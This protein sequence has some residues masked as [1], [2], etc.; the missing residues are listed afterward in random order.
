MIEERMRTSRR[1]VRRGA[2]IGLAAALAAI[3]A[4]PAAAQESLAT[5]SCLVPDS[6]S[7]HLGRIARRVGNDVGI[8]AI[9]VESGVRV[10]FNGERTFPMASV[11]K[12]PM[13]LEYLR[14]VDAGEIDPSERIVVPIT[15]FRP[16]NSPLASWSGGRA[17]HVTIDSLFGLMIGASDNTATDVILELSGGPEAADRRIRDLGVR[18]VR[19]DR[20]EAR[21]FADLSGLPDTIPESELYR[22]RYF[23]LRDGLEQTHRDSARVSYGSDPRDTATPDGMAEL[24][25]ELHRGAGLSPASNERLIEVMTASRSGQRRLRGLLPGSTHVAHKTGTMAGAVNDVGILTLPEGRGHL[26]VAAFVN[27]LHRTT[28]RRERTIA[29]MTRLL[30]DHFAGRPVPIVATRTD[31]ACGTTGPGE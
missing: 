14:R 19:V 23:R 1:G 26:V 21:T 29:E 17:V 8:T 22:Y 10:S 3:A 25:V 31:A 15:D 30:Y 9:H 5:V 12:V 4:H 11:S 24:L 16:G 18:G 2:A 27:T 28:W 13:A 20:S 7:G 6:V